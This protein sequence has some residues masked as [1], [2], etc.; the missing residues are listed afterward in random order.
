MFADQTFEF[1]AIY[2]SLALA[3][4]QSKDADSLQHN[5]VS[6]V[7]VVKAKQSRFVGT[8]TTP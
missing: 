1:K 3:L 6:Q 7:C 2:E 5:N 8:S 4:Q